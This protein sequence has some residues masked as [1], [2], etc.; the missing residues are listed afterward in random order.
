MN[1]QIDNDSP[2]SVTKVFHLHRSV[3]DKLHTEQLFCSKFYFIVT[4][5][6]PLYHRQ[7]P[8]P[9]AD[10]VDDDGLYE[11]DDDDDE[12]TDNENDPRGMLSNAASP[13]NDMIRRRTSKKL[14]IRKSSRGL[15]QISPTSRNSRTTTPSNNLTNRPMSSSRGSSRFSFKK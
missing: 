4:D 7:E 11:D 10:D 5:S 8:Q 2:R 6:R 13:T 15:S 12:A 1:E 9:L 14:S 3:E